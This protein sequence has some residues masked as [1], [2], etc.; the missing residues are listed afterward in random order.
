MPELSFE[1]YDIPKIQ[2]G[3]S[4]LYKELTKHEEYEKHN[5]NMTAIANNTHAPLSDPL[6]KNANWYLCIFE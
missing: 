5:M 1:K 2:N 6:E 4:L 3:R